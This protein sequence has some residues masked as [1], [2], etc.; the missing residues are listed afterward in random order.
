MP[1]DNHQLPLER[2]SKHRKCKAKCTQSANSIAQFSIYSINRKSYLGEIDQLKAL[3]VNQSLVSNDPNV[4]IRHPSAQFRPSIDAIEAFPSL[5][6]GYNFFRERLDDDAMKWRF[7]H[8]CPKNASRDVEPPG[9]SARIPSATPAHRAFDAQL[10]D[11]Q[12]RL[13]GLM[14]PLD[15]VRASIPGL[16]DAK[17]RTGKSVEPLMDI[18]ALLDELGRLNCPT[19]SRHDYRIGHHTGWIS[20]IFL[21]TAA[22]PSDVPDHHVLTTRPQGTRGD[23]SRY[24]RP[25]EQERHRGGVGRLSPPAIWIPFPDLHRSQKGRGTTSNPQAQGAQLVPPEATFQDGDPLDDRVHAPPGRLD[26]VNRSVRRVSTRV[27]PPI[28]A[29]LSTLYL[30]SQTLPIQSSSIWP[31]S[32]PVD[33]HQAGQAVAEMGPTP[34]HPPHGLFGR[35]YG[36]GIFSGTVRPPYAFG[37][38]EDGLP[39]MESEP[40]QVHPVP[41]HVNRTF[42]HANR[43]DDLVLFR[44]GEEGARAPSPRVPYHLLHQSTTSWA[45]LTSF[46]GTALAIQLGCVQARFQTRYDQCVS[47]FPIAHRLPNF[48]EDEG[49]AGLVAV[50][51]TAMEWQASDSA[52]TD[53]RDLHGCLQLGLGHCRRSDNS[54]RPLVGPGDTPTHQLEGIDDG[55]EGSGPLPSYYARDASASGGGQLVSQSL[56]RQVRGDAFPG[57][58]PAGSPNLTPLFPE[59]DPSFD[60]VCPLHLQSGRCSIPAV[61]QGDRMAPPSPHVS[62]IGKDLGSSSCRR[63]CVSDDDTPAPLCVTSPR[64]SSPVDEC[65]CSPMDPLSPSSPFDCAAVESDPSDHDAPPGSPSA[66]DPGD[67]E[68]AVSPLVAVTS[69]PR[70]G[71]AHRVASRR[72]RRPPRSPSHDPDG[73]ERRPSRRRRQSVTP[74]ITSIAER[75]LAVIA[76]TNTARAT[77][78]LRTIRSEWETWCFSSCIDPDR[79]SANDVIT[80][81]YCRTAPTKRTGSPTRHDPTHQP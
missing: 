57:I 23:R 41:I 58:E 72:R 1:L 74:A 20:A 48:P 5:A 60:G 19:T 61:D 79:P 68:L 17:I 54:G 6:P 4:T 18:E 56:P 76:S 36:H 65:P 25:V 8:D 26:D 37:L 44:P 22:D 21:F 2:L 53:A 55:V 62:P 15:C 29:S 27:D 73:M 67:P 45:E 43:F 51:A 33:L 50:S 3:L 64:P 75:E 28:V 30:E 9:P 42:G 70:D 46:A 52:S 35:L 71:P 69:P 63:L 47:P 77:R 38:G 81:V 78:R 39:W 40:W 11:I 16:E 49:R 31:V 12:S 7:L 13:I 34:W 66:R 14:R 10:R 24:S 59:P 80:Y 32:L